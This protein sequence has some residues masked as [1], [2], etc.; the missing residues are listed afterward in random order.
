MTY[1][2]VFVAAPAQAPPG[3]GWMVIHL[4]QWCWWECS[5]FIF[6]MILTQDVFLPTWSCFNCFSTL[7]LLVMCVAATCPEPL[8]CCSCCY[9]TIPCSNDH[10]ALPRSESH[11]LLWQ[12]L[13]ASSHLIMSHPTLNCPLIVVWTAHIYHPLIE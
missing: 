13:S 9:C 2:H 10:L 12:F 6:G 4:G 3:L 11:P 1:R 5:P 8:K 7:T